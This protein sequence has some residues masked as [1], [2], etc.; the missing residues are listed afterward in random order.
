LFGS[1]NSRHVEE[2]KRGEGGEAVLLVVFARK[3][4]SCESVYLRS[5][6]LEQGVGEK[7]NFVPGM[8]GGKKEGKE[9]KKPLGA[10]YCT[11]RHMKSIGET[12]GCLRKERGGGRDITEFPQSQKRKKEEKKRPAPFAAPGGLGGLNR[13]IRAAEGEEKGGG[14]K[15]GA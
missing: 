7:G 8:R 4:G 12:F 3:R 11:K 15:G 14:G 9:N 2:K 10:H 1:D 6:S 5:G 13:T